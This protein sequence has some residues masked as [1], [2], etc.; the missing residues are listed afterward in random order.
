MK[1]KA[2]LLLLLPLMLLLAT[3]KPA[4]AQ[5][6][7]KAEKTPEA[8]R[9]LSEEQKQAINRIRVESE[10]RAAP[11]ALRL[12]EIVSKIYEN[13]LADKPDEQLRATLS[14]Q[15][16]EVAWELLSIKGQSI[17]DTVNVLTPEQ[18]RLVKAEM[19][20]SGASGDLSEVI[21][22]M[23]NLAGK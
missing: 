14:E 18:K 21:A 3:A 1:I 2:T 22:R 16:K 4:T 7:P 12:A 5:T 8:P 20:K 9:S 10:K 15:M 11:A 23:F 6:A 13:M 17:R 19:R